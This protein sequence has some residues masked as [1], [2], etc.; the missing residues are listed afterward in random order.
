VGL[1]AFALAAA[2]GPVAAAEAS[3]AE[4]D[5]HFAGR[6]AGT[7]DSECAP[8]AIDAALAGYRSALA[9]APDSLEARVGILRSLFFRGG[10]CGESP[11]AQ[12]RTFEEAKRAAE[13]FQA[14]IE[15]RTGARVRRDRPEPF[16][17]V[18]GS[19]ALLFWCG[20]S[21]GQWSLD[22]K[23]AA[24]WQG[25]A[26]RIRD[27]GEA[28]R[29]VDPGYEQGSPDL[30]LGRLHV[31]SPRIPLVTG[32]VSRRRG[33]EHL[34]RAHALGPDNSVA[35]YFL[36]AA[37][38]EHEPRSRAEA[39][40]LLRACADAEPRSAYLVEDRH[41]AGKARAALRALGEAP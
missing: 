17:T 18:P 32:F 6:A 41:Y 27:L 14:W 37:I 7:R 29:A 25:A 40:A 10:F 5:R 36:A 22:H 8:A 23:L 9:A 26:G 3:L 35:R 21:W 12:K 19:A 4:A 33:L 39:E 34:R 31:E 16:R 28:A 24:A 2:L 13:A 20:V 11:T 15:G 1:A 38:L 30:L